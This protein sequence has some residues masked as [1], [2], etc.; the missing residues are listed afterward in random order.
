MM[1][2]EWEV[3]RGHSSMFITDQNQGVNTQNPVNDDYAAIG[4]V[5][6]ERLH[7]RR[8]VGTS[9]V[10]DRRCALRGTPAAFE[11]LGRPLPETAKVSI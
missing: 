6:Q 8:I 2:K 5:E 3:I 9:F 10:S 11:S 7:L 4:E 1:R